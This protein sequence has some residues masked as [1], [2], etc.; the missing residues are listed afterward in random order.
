MS[1][2]LNYYIFGLIFSVWPDSFNVIFFPKSFTTMASWAPALLWVLSQKSSSFFQLLLASLFCLSSFTSQIKLESFFLKIWRAPRDG[3]RQQSE[4]RRLLGK[5]WAWVRHKKASSFQI[6]NLFSRAIWGLRFVLAFCNLMQ[7]L[8]FLFRLIS[9][10][11]WSALVLYALL[12]VWVPWI[13]GFDV[14]SILVEAKVDCIVSHDFVV[15]L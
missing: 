8:L 10:Q 12:L 9:G 7:H 5:A 1:F 14:P 2:H 15:I 13:F 4:C 6:S 3:K 11:Q